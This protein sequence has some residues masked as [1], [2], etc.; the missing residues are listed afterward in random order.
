MEVQGT[1]KGRCHPAKKEW[2]EFDPEVSQRFHDNLVKLSAERGIMPGAAAERCGIPTV[3]FH[4]MADGKCGVLLDDAIAAVRVL[5]CG[6]EEL[7]R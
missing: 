3:A 7:V 5:G 6:Y 1:V 2:Q 4:A